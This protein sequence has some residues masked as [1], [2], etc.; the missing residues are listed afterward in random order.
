MQPKSMANFA[1]ATVESTHGSSYALGFT[2]K[3]PKLPTRFGD[4]VWN[5]IIM[6]C[7]YDAVVVAVKVMRNAFAFIKTKVCKIYFHVLFDLHI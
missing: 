4:K 3:T 1:N 5:Q 7:S 2:F 6:L